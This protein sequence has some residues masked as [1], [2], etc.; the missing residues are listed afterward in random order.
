MKLWSGHFHTLAAHF[1]PSQKRQGVGERHVIHLPDGDQIEGFLYPGT[2]N[3]VVALFHGLS[4]SDSADYMD[5]STILF[6]KEGHSVFLTNHRG[7]QSLMHAQNSVGGAV[8]TLTAKS[9]YHSGR[10]EDI[11]AVVQYLRR[12]L[13]NKKIVTVGFSLSGNM[14]L[15]L[16]SGMRGE[17]LPDAAIT[18]NAPIN[19]ASSAKA[20][21]TGF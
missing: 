20:L 21:Q 9:P 16:L 19:L 18:V 4:G 12:L 8:A 7:V 10:G 14:I 15:V 3:I 2:T 11:S 6:A 1:L 17:H 5:R 13:P